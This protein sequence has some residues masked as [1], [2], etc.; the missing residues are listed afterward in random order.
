MAVAAGLPSAPYIV[1]I[2]GLFVSD[3]DGNICS[4]VTAGYLLGHI[5]HEG[6]CTVGRG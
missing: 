6:H 2:A 1:G 5:S 3:V 4:V